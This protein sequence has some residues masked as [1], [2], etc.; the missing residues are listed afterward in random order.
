MRWQAAGKRR[1]FP[2]WNC[3][4]IAV[5]TERECRRGF[6]EYH[7][8]CPCT[9]G[10]LFVSTTLHQ[11]RN[12]SLL[13]SAQALL[14]TNNVTLIALNGLVG[15]Q[16]AADKSFATLPVTT[17]IIGS[18]LFAMPASHLM[19]RIGRRAGFLVGTGCGLLGGA[20]ATL[21]VALQSMA[22]LCLGT[23]VLGIYAAFGQFYRFAA[24]DAASPQFK[25]K[26]ISLVVAGGLV[27]GIVG[28]ALSKW[29]RHLAATEFL[30]SYA[31]LMVFCL[32]TAALLTFLRMPAAKAGVN[33]APAR[34]L[35]AIVRQPAFVVATLV[36]ALGYGVM[37]LLMTA[38]PLA[39]G[40][41]GYPYSDAANVISAH[42]IAMFA[43]SFFTGSLIQRAGVL[44]VMLAG[45]AIMC[46]CLAV[47]LSGVSVAHFWW[48]LVLLGIGW[49]FMY[50]GGS[51]LLTECYQPSE[52][53]RAQGLHDLLVF[54]TTAISSFASG[55]LLKSNGWAMLNYAAVPLVVL[56]A[57]AILWLLK[58]R[59]AD[60]P[61]K[62]AAG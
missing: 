42:V 17:Q 59:R 36:S 26:A 16:L 5:P 34:S 21:G 58:R 62:L 9:E 39:M 20:I 18:A 12:I 28:P 38:T 44:K 53:A 37:N 55:L 30:A 52:K 19:Q 41:C 46:L 32:C 24:A 27:G 1:C 8:C 48:S 13:A 57:L 35:G 43:P 7:P 15:Y 3:E 23:F 49:N 2:P 6:L 25:A 50:V 56:S 60:L 33:A 40:V 51:T 10:C 31:S 29:T 11:N 47:S 14:F 54:C 61:A 45:V 4:S 22:L